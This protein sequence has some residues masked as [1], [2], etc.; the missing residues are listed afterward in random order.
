MS[1]TGRS[2]TVH[3]IAGARPNFMKV[4]PLFHA[5]NRQSWCNPV[6]VHTGQHFDAN[7]S[8]AF[9]QDLELPRPHIALAAG[10]GSHAEQ[11][12]SV[13]VAYERV[14]LAERPDWTVVVGDVN[15]TLAC[16]L[17]AKKLG[18][19]VAHLEAG[20]RAG[21][22]GMPEE[23]NRI[24]TD[25]IS[26]LL[27][28]PSRDADRNLKREGIAASRIER[29]GNIMIDSLEMLSAAIRRDRT[30]ERLKLSE[31]RYGLVTLHRP[32]NVDHEERLREIVEALICSS[33]N[34]RLVF[35]VH[36]RTAEKLQDYDLVGKLEKANDILRIPPIGYIGFMALMQRAALAIT[37]SG[38]IQE[39][40]SYLKIPCLTLREN[41]ERPITLTAGTNR[42]AKPAQL[43]RLIGKILKGDWPKGKRIELWDGR[44]ASR[45]CASLRRAL[46]AI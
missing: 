17:T 8:E 31:A 5:L 20:L 19:P 9:W 11:T 21:D 42:L 25:A 33:R 36:P 28:T 16:A 24:C 29:V 2:Y 26:D 30:V 35:P 27:W 3:L 41:T 13:M 4:A 43:D 15:S 46:G 10:R 1:Q 12:A 22:L 32:S 37:D 18:I 7:M 14:C 44:T 34:L 6:L 23:I 39:E 45:V 38:G 40:A